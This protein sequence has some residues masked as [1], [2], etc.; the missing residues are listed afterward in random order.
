[1]FV[2]MIHRDEQ[3][4]GLAYKALRPT[5]L[6]GFQDQS[7]LSRL[8]SLLGDRDASR[9]NTTTTNSSKLLAEAV[10]LWSSCQPLNSSC[11]RTNVSNTYL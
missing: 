3:R 6:N 7:G 5:L 9:D 11:S 2:G 8:L 10:K 1:M 4:L